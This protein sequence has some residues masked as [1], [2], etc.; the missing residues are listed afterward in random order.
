MCRASG[1]GVPS[2]GPWPTCGRA[3]PRST[4]T[5]RSTRRSSAR[6][7]LTGP[8][9]STTTTSSPATA[10]SAPSPSAPEPPSSG[11]AS[12][13]TSSAPRPRSG[14]VLLGQ[15]LRSDRQPAVHDRLA[16]HPLVHLL[17]LDEDRGVAVEVGD[18]EEDLGMGFE[19]G[20]LLVQVFDVAGEDRTAGR[21]LLAEP[22]DVRLAERPFPGESLAAHEPGAAT[23]AGPLRDLGQLHRHSSRI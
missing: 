17:Q 13:A 18:V 4:S 8:P 2:N 3:S 12:S 6:A 5:L 7:P 14:Q 11:T 1:A 10:R 9:A 23:E 20:L 15:L 22:L 19:H 16:Q 21:R